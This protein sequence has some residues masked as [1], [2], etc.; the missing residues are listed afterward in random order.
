[1]TLKDI[2]CGVVIDCSADTDVDLGF[3]VLLRETYG[4]RANPETNHM[5][6]D[7]SGLSPRKVDTERGWIRHMFDLR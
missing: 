1:M 7:L 5:V 6:I 4:E 2:P 3:F